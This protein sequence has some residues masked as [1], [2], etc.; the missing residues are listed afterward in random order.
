MAYAL[1]LLFD[2]KS[3]EQIL[4]L[5]RSIEKNGI[6]NKFLE[7][8]SI[9][10]IALFVFDKIDEQQAIK[11]VDN[12]EIKSI[13]LSIQGLGTFHGSENTIFLIP[14]VTSELLKIHESFYNQFSEITDCWEYYSPKNW[15]P[16]CTVAINIEEDKFLNAFQIIRK[17]FSPLAVKIEKINLIKF[18]PIELLYEK[19][20]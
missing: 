13:E 3:E 17:N 12:F 5:A 6:K 2:H 10:H 1:E 4:N 7:I 11:L 19:N 14:K 18:H 8:N 20:I 9:P 16:H 15:I